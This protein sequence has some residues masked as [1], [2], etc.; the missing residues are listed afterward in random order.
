MCV[1]VPLNVHEE[2]VRIYNLLPSHPLTSRCM[3]N[4]CRP[5]NLSV[6]TPS[7][8][9]LAVK[10]GEMSEVPQIE[11]PSEPSSPLIWSHSDVA[12]EHHKGAAYQRRC[13][14]VCVC[15]SER[16]ENLPP[17]HTHHHHH[18]WIQ[19]KDITTREI[20]HTT[21]CWIDTQIREE[22]AT[23]GVKVHPSFA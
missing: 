13:Y 4:S 23:T 8:R 14:L 9:Y 6:V 10:S 1:R 20:Q 19:I 2:D 17:A 11:S 21:I 3:D 5:G 12:A 18:H 15:I 7:I 16:R 22:K